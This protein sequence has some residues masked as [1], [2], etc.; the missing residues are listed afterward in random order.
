M[1][2]TNRFTPSLRQGKRGGKPALLALFFP[3][4]RYFRNHLVAAFAALGLDLSVPP[5]LFETMGT[6]RFSK[7]VEAAGKPIVHV[8]WVD[9]GKDPVLQKAIKSNR[10]MTIHQEPGEKKTDYGT[11]GFQKNIQG[12]ILIFP[13]SLKPFASQH[14]VGVKYDLLEWPAVAIEKQAPKP[15]SLKRPQKTKSQNAK[16]PA[17]A[18][19]PPVSEITLTPTV[20]KF[21]APESDEQARPNDEVEQIKAQIRHAMKALEEGR[22]VAAF[23]LLKQIVDAD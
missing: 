14:V 1:I 11:I 4:R 13:N 17:K 19:K 16:M 6:I 7:I 10:V 5:P 23:N 9:P 2:F 20:V 22:Q 3:A 21:P 15:S 8:L 18:D 12:Q